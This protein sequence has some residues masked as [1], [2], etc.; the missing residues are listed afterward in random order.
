VARARSLLARSSP[1]LLIADAR[2]QS[3]ANAVA[4]ALKHIIPDLLFSAS[5]WRCRQENHAD[6]NDHANDCIQ[7]SKRRRS[8]ST[9]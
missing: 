5:K 4:A 8:D 7:R 3:G 1:R 6:M 9:V 2:P